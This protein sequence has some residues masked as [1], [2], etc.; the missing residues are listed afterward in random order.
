MKKTKLLVLLFALIMTLT[1]FTGCSNVETS[2]NANEEN[3]VEEVDESKTDVIEKYGVVIDEKTVTFTDAR[4]KEVTIKK[5][6]E[7]V[8]CLFNS[9]M[10]IWYKCGGEVVGRIESSKEKP[11]EGSEDAEIVGTNGEPSLE[12]IISLKPDLVIGAANMKTQLKVCEMLEGSNIDVILLHNE[13]KEEYFKTVRIFSALTNRDDLYEK[14]EGEVRADIEA[15]IDRVPKDVNPKVLLL[16]GSSKGISVRGS[17]SV[18]GEM[19][20]DLN[21]INISDIINDSADSKIFSMEK[22]IEED[23]DFI[24]V[25][26]MGKIEKVEERLKKDV[27]SNSA[28]GSLKAV[29]ND[30]Y[31]I[32]P[33]E[34]YLYKPN[35]RYGEAYEGLAK[36]LYPDVFN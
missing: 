23:P 7:R 6:P 10:D 24:F 21:T 20:K 34:L 3:K 9:Y 28:W 18:V 17:N 27:E 15:I 2:N 33:K 30:R 12:K 16:F 22:I 26:T 36:I 8:V 11:V 35:D 14:Y 32:L 19:L 4:D 5:N 25:Q 13:T 29:K 1:V 31:I